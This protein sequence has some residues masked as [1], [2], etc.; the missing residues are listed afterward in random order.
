MK[1]SQFSDAQK[2]FVLEQ[3]YRSHKLRS[4]GA[5]KRQIMPDVERR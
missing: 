3:G 2:A 1:A 5:A 4:H